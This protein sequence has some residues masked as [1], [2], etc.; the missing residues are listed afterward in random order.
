MRRGLFVIAQQNRPP[1]PGGLFRKERKERRKYEEKAMILATMSLIRP[2]LAVSQALFPCYTYLDAE[3]KN[4]FPAADYFSRAIIPLSV[5]FSIAPATQEVLP[6]LNDRGSPSKVSAVPP[7]S[8]T[9]RA[10]AA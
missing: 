2:A 5:T 9:M 7:A 4:L 1:I 10:A 6:T 8:L 3:S